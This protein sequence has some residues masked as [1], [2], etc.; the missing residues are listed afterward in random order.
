M[1]SSRSALRRA[2]L[3]LVLA[4]TM[5]ALGAMRAGPATANSGA[6]YYHDYSTTYY[7]FL[8]SLWAADGAASIYPDTAAANNLCTASKITGALENFKFLLEDLWL[9]KSGQQTWVEFG[10]MDACSSTNVRTR[11]WRSL[12]WLNGVPAVPALNVSCSHV[13]QLHKFRIQYSGSGT[14]W[15][16][17]IDSTQVASFPNTTVPCCMNL[18]QTGVESNAVGTQYLYQTFLQMSLRRHSDATWWFW[19]LVNLNLVNGEDGY[20]GNHVLGG[21]TRW[22]A[23]ANYSN[24]PNDTPTPVLSVSPTS[25]YVNSTWFTA[26]GCSS[27][28]PDLYGIRT[29]DFYWGDGSADTVTS[30]CTASHTYSSTGSKTMYLSVTNNENRTSG[31]GS[32]HTVSVTQPNQ[33]PVASI[34]TAPNPAMPGGT[35]TGNGSGSY[36]PDGSVVDYC[37]YWGDGLVTCTGSSATNHSYRSE[38]SY[39]VLL[40]VEDN[41]GVWSWASTSERVCYG[42]LGTCII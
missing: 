11:C 17:F 24:C 7:N 9:I 35:V 28:T 15:N 18:Y 29:Y 8:P 21:Y 6:P 3:A 25:G 22:V 19:G 4:C 2:Q 1:S 30:S 33:P 34:S 37:F 5:V 14:T 39:T 27:Y 32:P 12:A 20:F 16:L 40:A 23:C 13:N 10:A 42:V 36:D 26:N 31:Y 41:S 38:G